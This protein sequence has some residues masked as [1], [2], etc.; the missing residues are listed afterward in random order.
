MNPPAGSFSGKVW[1]ARKASGRR[2][3]GGGWGGGGG[4]EAEGEYHGFI[5]V[6][7]PT[8]IRKRS[9]AAKYTNGT[10]KQEQ[11]WSTAATASRPEN[12]SD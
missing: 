6:C 1:W 8:I 5:V 2:C 4:E 9:E 3:K 7:F 10:M 11:L 12:T